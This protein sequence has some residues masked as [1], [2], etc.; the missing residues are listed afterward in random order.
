VRKNAE[1]RRKTR[2]AAPN[3]SSLPL[4]LHASGRAPNL[5]RQKTTLNVEPE[6]RTGERT[7][8]P[9]ALSPPVLPPPLILQR[10]AHRRT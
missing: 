1:P 9:R 8:A 4:V 2:S 3:R 10:G 5:E 7:G 6:C